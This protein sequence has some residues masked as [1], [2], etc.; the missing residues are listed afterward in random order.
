MAA[1]AFDEVG[2]LV[3]SLHLARPG[4]SGRG[5]L[6]EG[7]GA[8]GCPAGLGVGC[9]LPGRP[10]SAA[11]CS[12]TVSF[13]VGSAVWTS[14]GLGRCGRGEQ[15]HRNRDGAA[16]KLDGLLMNGGSEQGQ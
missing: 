12:W 8:K 11:R 7:P 15:Q 10:F 1:T 14:G 16:A 9:V 5:I 2:K 6:G 13:P 3:L 4:N